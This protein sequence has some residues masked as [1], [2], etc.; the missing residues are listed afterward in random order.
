MDIDAWLPLVLAL[1][2]LLV[3][4]VLLASWLR[5]K[6]RLEQ[7]L[8]RFSSEEGAVRIGSGGGEGSRRTTLAATLRMI[9]R[10]TDAR[11]HTDLATLMRQAGLKIQP[12]RFGILSVLAGAGFGLL[13]WLFFRQWTAA[14][15]LAAFVAT[16]PPLFLLR[17]LKERR[18]RAFVDD[19]PN[20]LDAIARGVRAGLPLGESLRMIA[21]E[22]AGPV[23]EEFRTL[24]ESQVL[25]LSVGDG[26]ARLAER[27]PAVETRFF[28]IALQIQEKTGGN[29]ADIVES[30]AAALRERRKMRERIGALSMEAKSSAVILAGLPLVVATL[31]FVSNHNFLDAFLTTQTGRLALA[32]MAG[33]M[34]LGGLIMRAMIRIDV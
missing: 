23:S 32:A 5:P 6:P 19:F 20:A 16:A 11:G 2:L 31:L 29:I 13:V 15:G 17:I 26:A 14:I 12:L 10:K 9:D 28:A 33:S 27:V 18:I 30:L 3:S 1:A 21:T 34:L 25:G 22:T 8:V 7:L 4:G 24:V